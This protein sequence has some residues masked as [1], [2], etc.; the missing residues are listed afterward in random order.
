MT[1]DWRLPD[2]PFLFK[3]SGLAAGQADDYLV[4]F[5]RLDLD[6]SMQGQLDHIARLYSRLFLLASLAMDEKEIDEIGP[7]HAFRRASLFGD[8]EGAVV[9]MAAPFPYCLAR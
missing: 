2:D 8:C 5:D 3:L 4:S 7:A 9:A 1:K 6:L